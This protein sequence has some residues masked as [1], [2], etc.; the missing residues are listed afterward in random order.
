MYNLSLCLFVSFLIFSI[1]EKKRESPYE[2]FISSIIELNFYEK[3]Q[4]DKETKVKHFNC[5]IFQNQNPQLL[6][7]DLNYIYH[8]IS[9][10]CDKFQ[11]L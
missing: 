2:F 11:R 1:L 6:D 5:V 3:R 4:R 7:N 8:N 10:I 9:N